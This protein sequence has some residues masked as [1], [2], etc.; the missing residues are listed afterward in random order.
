[1]SRSRLEGELDEPRYQFFL[2]ALRG[3]PAGRQ[4]RLELGRLHP[5]DLLRVQRTQIQIGLAHVVLHLQYMYRGMF[6]PHPPGAGS[7]TQARDERRDERDVRDGTGRCAI[8][9]STL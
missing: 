8:E 9:T 2:V 5:F 4:V 3:R 7:S 6:V 1:M